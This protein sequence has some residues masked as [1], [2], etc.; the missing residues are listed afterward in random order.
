MEVIFGGEGNQLLMAV[1]KHAHAVRRR[2]CPAL[3]DASAAPDDDPAGP[4]RAS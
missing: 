3:L 4:L 1:N 2:Q